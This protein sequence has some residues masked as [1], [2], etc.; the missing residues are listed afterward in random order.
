[1]TRGL[2]GQSPANVQNFLRGVKYPATKED[3]IAAGKRNNAPAG[4]MMIIERLSVEK[5]GGPQEVMKTYSADAKA[6]KAA[7]H[8]THG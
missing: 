3:L 5:F 7:D 8:T 6:V 4:V 2:G 1:M